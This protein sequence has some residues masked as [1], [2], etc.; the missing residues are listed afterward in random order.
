[1]G[2]LGIPRPEHAGQAIGCGVRE[3]Q[4]LF[5]RVERLQGDHGTEDL[6]LIGAALRPQAL[7]HGGSDVP[8]VLQFAFKAHTRTP[9]QDRASFFLGDGDVTEDLVH[10]GLA[11][12][13]AQIR[14]LR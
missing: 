4:R 3:G 7:D 2:A 5:F 11:H 14:V 6:F 12:H 8:S 9:A 10:V 13:S 1:M